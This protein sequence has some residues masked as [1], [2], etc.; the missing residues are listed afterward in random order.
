MFRRNCLIIAITCFAICGI[1]GCTAFAP[2]E[3][4]RKELREYRELVVRLD[5]KVLNPEA[6]AEI[7]VYSETGEPVDAEVDVRVEVVGYW[8]VYK[9][10]NSVNMAIAVLGFPAIPFGL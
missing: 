8:G 7:P 6:A 2:Q 1:I 3:T 9:R 4:L 10:L 5:G